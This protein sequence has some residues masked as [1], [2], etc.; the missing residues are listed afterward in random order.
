MKKEQPSLSVL[1]AGG[2]HGFL[3]VARTWLER[4]PYIEGVHSAQSGAAA[5]DAMETSKIDLVLVDSMLGDMDE[6]ELTRRIK[7]RF[8]SP[9]VVLLVM[10]D[11]AAV[12]EQ[13]RL[14]GADACVDK[15]ALTRELGPML[16]G[17]ADRSR[18]ERPSGKPRFP[19]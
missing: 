8:C 5:L 9:V 12:R 6:F 2:N 7:D 18:R 19:L 11:Y 17:F 16:A 15:S 4:E 13:A 10:F 3:S 14:A 1:I